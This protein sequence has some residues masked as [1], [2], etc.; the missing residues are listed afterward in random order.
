MRKMLIQGQYE[1][2]VER[3]GCTFDSEANRLRQ[4]AEAQTLQI[5]V[6]R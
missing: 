4:E 2:D 3:S 5:E 6:F 1:D